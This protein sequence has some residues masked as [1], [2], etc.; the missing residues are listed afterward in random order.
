M[1]SLGIHSSAM[2][3]QIYDPYRQTMP[4]MGKQPYS[5]T[6]PYMGINQYGM[7]NHLNSMSHIG[8]FQPPS[9]HSQGMFQNQ[10]FSE[11]ENVQVLQECYV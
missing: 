3:N 5:S 4:Y 8:G 10:M 1:H 6:Q 7:P 9:F 2:Q 11:P